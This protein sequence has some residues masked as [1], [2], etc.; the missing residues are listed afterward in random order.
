MLFGRSKNSEFRMRHRNRQP[1]A[2]HPL[3]V[4]ALAIW[5]ALLAGL[6]VMV[7]PANT[8]N[9]LTTATALGV[10]ENFARYFFAA[11]AALIGAACGYFIATKWR[12]LRYG[13]TDATMDH[14]AEHL[15]PIDPV[16]ELGSES[17]D[18]PLEYDRDQDEPAE[19]EPLELDTL[20]EHPDASEPVEEQAVEED[21]MLELGADLEAD[22]EPELESIPEP[23]SEPVTESMSADPLEGM[24]CEP[25]DDAQEPANR[26]PTR[27]RRMRG[28]P[29]ELVQALGDHRARQAALHKDLLDLGEF[30]QLAEHKRSTV[31]PKPTPKANPAPTAID[32]LRAVP[33]QDLSLVQMVERL[34]VALHE[35]Q[36]AARAKPQPEQA[37]ERDAALAEALK[38]LSLFTERG[39]APQS[40]SA[41]NDQAS[42]GGA[43]DGT[44]AELRDALS[45]LQTMR[46]AA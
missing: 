23:E 44:E 35:R 25:A 15:R 17:L 39:V 2:V 27:R 37:S 13:G 31:A 42:V 36:D 9:Q 33:P 11:L 38:A 43:N 6:I 26:L 46:G 24:H 29:V 8:I 16:A 5:A 22:I 21:G 1:I 45:K 3:F 34:A 19:E 10:L 40:Q 7:L 41:E 18:T 14:T 30:S 28:K 20:A 32:K 12:D 4:P